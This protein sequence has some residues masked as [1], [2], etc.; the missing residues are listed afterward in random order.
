MHR[1]NQ[2]V[3]K[4]TQPFTQKHKHIETH[5]HKHE[6]K[7]NKSHKVEIEHLPKCHT[8]VHQRQKLVN[9][10][11]PVWRKNVAGSNQPKYKKHS[12]QLFHVVKPSKTVCTVSRYITRGLYQRETSNHSLLSLC[13]LWV[14]QC[15]WW[16][17]IVSV[18]LVHN[19]NFYDLASV[20]IRCPDSINAL[21]HT[22][23]LNDFSPVWSLV[24]V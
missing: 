2:P 23:Y 7:V 14:W 24:L 19:E 4:T 8:A 11:K 22:W 12:K 5:E 3:N 10:I 17:C 1:W 18:F 6:V 21:S 20:C 16:K 15:Q 9:H 13:T